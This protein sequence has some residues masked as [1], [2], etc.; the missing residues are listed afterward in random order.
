[1]RVGTCGGRTNGLLGTGILRRRNEPLA[2]AI[3]RVINP[4]LVIAATTPEHA[5]VIVL[6]LRVTAE[7]EIVRH[8]VTALLGSTRLHS[9]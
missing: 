8:A 1:M 4:P 3:V 6:A 2:V 5:V 9:Q 7:T